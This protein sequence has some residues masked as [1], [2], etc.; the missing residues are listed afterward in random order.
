MDLS[1]SSS[2]STTPATAKATSSTD[3]KPLNTENSL[4]SINN[5]TAGSNSLY[6]SAMDNM[7]TFV[8][9]SESTN[10]NSTLNSTTNSSTPITTTSSENFSH[11]NS[12]SASSGSMDFDTTLNGDSE[13]AILSDNVAAIHNDFGPAYPIN[14]NHNAINASMLLIQSESTDTNTSQEEVDPKSK[15]ANKTIFKTDNPD[16]SIIEINEN[17]IRDQDI[18]NSVLVI[19]TS[20]DDDISETVDLKGH[21]KSISDATVAHNATSAVAST[22]N[23]VIENVA[24][25][26]RRKA[27]SLIYSSKQKLNIA[28]AE[29][30]AAET[31]SPASVGD[32]SAVATV[33]QTKREIKIYD[34]LE[35][36]ERNLPS[37]VTVLD[38]PFGSKVYLVGTAHFSEESQD[39]VSFVIRNI[40]PDVVMVELCPS[41]I[42]ILKL[43]EKT[44]LEEA[45][46]FN[47]AKIRSIIHSHGYINGIFF[48]L[49]LQMSAQI[50]KDLGM[51]PGGEFRR[52]FEEIHKLHGCV[53]HLGDRP[54]RIT[55]HRALRALSLWQTVKLVWRL[56]SSDTISIEE[57]EECKQR[58]LL[59]KLMQEMAGEFPEFSDVFVKE[60]DLYLCHSLQMA[61]LPQPSAD[62]TGEPRPVR[63]VGVV[64]IGHA[65]GIAKMWGRVDPHIIPAI[66][67]IPPA[68]LSTRICKYTVKYGLIGLTLYGV[69]KLLRPHL[70]RLR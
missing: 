62:G 50:A 15:L 11:L 29:A 23:T 8:S 47:L 58:D 54:I 25:K 12:S 27:E 31:A 57:V 63:V 34:T 32:T 21:T 42:P 24:D 28:I 18:E 2:S 1:S 6:D 59:E 16:L 39:D 19:E 67:E 36:F 44:L 13:A 49:L 55:L 22:H 45:K 51:A 5:D 35:E 37:T 64:G 65:N 69:F 70:G 48:I 53:L 10:N 9:F 68:S 60:R 52:A 41:R 56:T 40:R 43:D 14:D 46:S 61:A 3:R 17:S 26:R 66:M 20:S 7:T 4:E 38:T 33:P 30:S